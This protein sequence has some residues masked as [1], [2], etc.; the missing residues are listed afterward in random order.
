[1]EGIGGLHHLQEDREAVCTN[2]MGVGGEAGCTTYM[3][4]RRVGF[5]HQHGERVV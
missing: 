5:H 2:H 1:M 3:G 4:K